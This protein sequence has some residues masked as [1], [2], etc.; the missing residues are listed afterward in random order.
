MDDWLLRVLT[1]MVALLFA[2]QILYVFVVVFRG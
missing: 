1:V 2:V